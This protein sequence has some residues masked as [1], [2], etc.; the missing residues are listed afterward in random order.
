MSSRRGVL[1]R[2]LFLLAGS[3]GRWLLGI[4]YSAIHIADGRS[5]LAVLNRHP[6][7]AGIYAFWHSH[8]LSM[9]WHCRAT[10]AAILISPSRDG[11]YIARIAGSLGYRSVRGSSSRRGM[12]SLKELVSIG[13]SGKSVAITPDG[14]R[15]PRYSV[16]PGVLILAQKTGHPITPMA[17]G[18]SRFWELPSWDRFRIPKPFC[19]GYF[20]WGKPLHVPADADEST[21]EK[22]ARELRAR[23]I[24][25]EQ[26]ADRIAVNM[27]ANTRPA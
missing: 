15:G 18:L 11:E 8:Q 23:M 9:S 3:L 19:K 26:Y 13:L 14:P 24:E 4:Y 21:L 17:I 20:C 16:K 5:A 6:R 12:A 22:L 7:P 25:L 2:F 10:H 27:A 1:Q